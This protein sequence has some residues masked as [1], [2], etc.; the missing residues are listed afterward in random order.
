M[1]LSRSL[2]ASLSSGLSNGA[3]L[4]VIALGVVAISAPHLV[5]L[6]GL[7]QLTV[8]AVMAIFALSQGFIWGF[9]G[10]MSFGQAAFLGLG[11]YAYAISVMNL[12]D[13]TMPVVLAVMT[14]MLFAAL[15]GY[16]MFY[17][18]ISD[19]YVAVITLTVSVI[20]YQLTN[21]TSGSQY[22]IGAVELG[23]FNG[24]PAIPALNAIGFPDSPLDQTGVW[25]V[26]MGCLMVIYLMLR[27][28]LASRF[29][30]VIVGIRE[31]ETR[32]QLLGYDVRLYRL[33]AF[34]IGAGIAGLAGCLYVNWAGFVS[35]NIFALSMSAQA[36]I[37]VLVG[38]LGT[39]IGPIVG[40]VLIQWFI[41]IIGDQ[42]YVDPSLGIGIVLVL[43]VLLVPQGLGMLMY[44]V[45][46]STF[47]KVLAINRARFLET[48]KPTFP[49]KTPAK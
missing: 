8:L 15:L 44:R 1:N 5:G 10:I 40:A 23:G 19:A 14:P 16:F 33:L 9:G 36:I 32:A 20:L 29:G 30:R 21:A 3:A 49:L 35:P 11:G 41:N 28:I 13:S 34:I 43:F 22:R 17:G 25:Y 12:G 48:P 6:Y 24:I 27:G 2:Y 47:R 26:T 18:R 37:F 31:N 39:L 38:G 4:L 7:T 42:H 46:M 45:V